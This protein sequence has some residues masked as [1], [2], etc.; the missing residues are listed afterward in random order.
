MDPED[1]RLPFKL[2]GAVQSP[3]QEV[4]L[5]STTSSVTVIVPLVTVSRTV[6]ENPA[7]TLTIGVV[8]EL[9]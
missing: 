7:G 1:S 6:A 2:S 8:S 4:V 5:V 3:V 9:S